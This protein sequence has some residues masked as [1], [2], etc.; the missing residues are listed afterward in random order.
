MSAE[1]IYKLIKECNN[2]FNNA[3]KCLNTARTRLICSKV[4]VC[5]CACM[6]ACVYV[7]MHVSLTM[8]S[9]PL[10]FYLGMCVIEHMQFPTSFDLNC[11]GA[12]RFLPSL[13]PR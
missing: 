12:D 5:V 6:R 7:C 10:K 11:F 8:C 9:G 1:V 4:V 13:F 3:T 2:T